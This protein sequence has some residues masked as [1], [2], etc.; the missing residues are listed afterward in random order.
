MLVVHLDHLCKVY[1]W[2]IININYYQQTP[3]HLGFYSSSIK[4][5]ITQ[6]ITLGQDNQHKTIPSYACT[7]WLKVS[8]MKLWAIE[9]C[10]NLKQIIILLQSSQLEKHFKIC[11]NKTITYL[12]LVWYFQITHYMWYFWILTKA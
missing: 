4:G 1:W 8:T 2:F 11:E 12:L 5:W 6:D 9:E 3:P 10:N 7:S